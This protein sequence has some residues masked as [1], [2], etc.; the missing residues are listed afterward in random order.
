MLCV[1]QSCNHTRADQRRGAW[2]TEVILNDPPPPL[3]NNVPQLKED[4]DSKK[5]TIRARFVG[6]NRG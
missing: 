1:A 6:V 3:P 4:G 5:L 2:I